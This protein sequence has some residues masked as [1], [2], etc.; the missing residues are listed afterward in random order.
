MATKK[1]SESPTSQSDLVSSLVQA[2][3]LTRPAQKK[4]AFNRKANTP[5]TPK[6][7][8]PKLKMKRKFYQHGVEIKAGKVNNEDIELLNKL[9]PGVYFDGNVKVNRR[10]D[11][12][13][14]IEYNVKTA[15]QR[16][17]LINQYGVRNFTDLVGKLVAE[18]SRPRA[19]EESIVDED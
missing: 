19:V 3:E 17:K 11:R 7:G 8:A 18:G 10:K 13:Y 15:S 1:K 6:D 4:T 9:K 14:D 12:G 16:L 5:W 2:I